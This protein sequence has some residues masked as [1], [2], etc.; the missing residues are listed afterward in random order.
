VGWIFFQGVARVTRPVK[1]YGSLDEHLAKLEQRGMALD[2]VFA[3][4]WLGSVGY[5]RLSGYWY[6]YRVLT[7]SKRGDTFEVGT[8]FADV[9]A[10]YEFDRK[11]RTLV[12]DGVERVEM[13]C[14]RINETVGAYGA[15]AYLDRAHFRP[16]FDHAA[17]LTHRTEAHRPFAPPQRCRATS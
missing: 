12:H 2:R 11:L 7:G 1:P 6:P 4:Q 13:L 10:L 15:L 14:T 3:A 8:S 5:Y 16:T 17:W 9:V